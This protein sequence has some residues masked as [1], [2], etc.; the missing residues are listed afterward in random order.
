MPDCDV[1]Y[2]LRTAAFGH[3]VSKAFATIC[4]DAGH[5]CSFCSI[6]RDAISVFEDLACVEEVSLFIGDEEYNQTRLSQRLSLEVSYRINGCWKESSL[7]EVYCAD[8]KIWRIRFKI[9]LIIYEEHVVERWPFIPVRPHISPD[10]SSLEYLNQARKWLYHCLHNHSTADCGK[11]MHSELPTR[12]MCVRDGS[13]DPFIYEAA[14]RETGEYAA[15][16]YCWVSKA[17]T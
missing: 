3:L 6:L 13:N 17:Q 1:C 5:R 16:S 10:P 7:F 8:S 4:K 14:P 15:L 11:Q 12:V 9:L 2:N